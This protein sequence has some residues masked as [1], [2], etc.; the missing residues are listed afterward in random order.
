LKTLIIA[1]AVGV[2]A[3]VAGVTI[4]HGAI[5]PGTPSDTLCSA[6]LDKAA[7]LRF[8]KLIQSK[9]YDLKVLE[10]TAFATVAQVR[11]KTFTT[12]LKCIDEGYFVF[13]VRVE[14]VNDRLKSIKVEPTRER[15]LPA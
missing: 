1:I 15:R 9:G 3:F 5:P 4:G 8:E 12:F 7:C 10:G 11:K 6:E 13:V 2:L 14:Y